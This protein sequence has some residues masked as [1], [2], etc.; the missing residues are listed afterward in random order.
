M[1]PIAREDPPSSLLPVDP[2]LGLGEVEL[3]LLFVVEVDTEGV[4]E[5]V[6]LLDSP[7]EAEQLGLINGLAEGVCKGDN[8]EVDGD[9][10]GLSEVLKGLLDC[11]KPLGIGLLEGDTVETSGGVGLLELLEGRWPRE[12][13]GEGLGV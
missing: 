12:T 3:L 13:L 5:A 7:G 11:R 2:R 4:G 9:D 1:V 8:I 10:V 6:I